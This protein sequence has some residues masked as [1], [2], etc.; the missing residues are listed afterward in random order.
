MKSWKYDGI[1]KMLTFLLST[2]ILVA[3]GVE[4]AVVQAAA[5]AVFLVSLLFFLW[6]RRREKQTQDRVEEWLQNPEKDVSKVEKRAEVLRLMDQYQWQLQSQKEME[7]ERAVRMRQ[8]QDYYTLWT[9]QIKTPIAAMKMVIDQMEEGEERSC[10]RRELFKIRQYVESALSYQRMETFHED[11]SLKEENLEELVKEAVKKF[12]FFF[13]GQRIS[14][15]IDVAGAK[16]VTD[17]KWFAVILEQ[18]LS[19][20]LKYTVQ[21]GVSIYWRN[22]CLFLEDTGIGI[23]KEDISRV[24]ERGF[25]GYNG[26]INQQSSGIGLYLSREIAEKLGYRMSIE[27]EP[28]KGTTVC[29]HMEQPNRLQEVYVTKM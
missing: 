19:N 21:G 6:N 24:F 7:E 2:G 29:I 12:S 26:R 20:A 14:V 8:D 3:V 13:I 22:D 11:L 17:K 4:K 28:G 5:G 23:R 16:V 18:I 9:H 25:C 27:S 10:L 1:E 15:N